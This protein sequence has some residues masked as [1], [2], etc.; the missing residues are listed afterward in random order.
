MMG[1]SK[2]PKMKKVKKVKKKETET[3]AV[4]ST[5]ANIDLLS[6]NDTLALTPAPDSPAGGDD[7]FDAFGSFQG[8]STS[9]GH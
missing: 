1:A 2:T 4:C 6:L 5:V 3:E 7:E 8:G 9:N